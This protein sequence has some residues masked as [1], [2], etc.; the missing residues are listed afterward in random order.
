M[1][2]CSLEENGLLLN[3]LAEWEHKAAKKI[4]LLTVIQLG[5]A[6]IVCV[7]IF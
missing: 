7:G 4:V 6:K 2:V 3:A 1:V 5:F